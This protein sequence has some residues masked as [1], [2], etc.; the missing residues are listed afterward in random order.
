M[1]IPLLLTSF[2]ASG[3]FSGSLIP[4]CPKSDTPCIEE[5][6]N[7]ALPKICDGI[8]ELGVEPS[9][10]QF[11]PF[12]DGDL[13]TL[14]YKLYNSSVTGFKKCIMSNL[15]FNDDFTAV[16]CDMNCPELMMVGQYDLTG[17]LISLP[18]EGNG[19]FTFVSRD[20]LLKFNVKLE[21]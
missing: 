13:S 21:K 7:V 14:K 5:S 1:Y 16:H 8:P 18:V 11:I 15:K 3:V 20:Y 4:P 9:V 2:L 10:P 17:Q 19:D 12:V 6:L